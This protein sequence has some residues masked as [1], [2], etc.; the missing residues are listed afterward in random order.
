MATRYFA[1]VAGFIYLAIGMLGFVPGLRELPPPQAP[2]V[3]I[4]AAHGYLFGLFPVN[5]LHNIVHIV[6]G[7]W[8]ILAF[9]T[10]AS[11]ISFAKGLAII[12]AVFAVMGLFP[13]LNTTF[14]LVPL[15]SHDIWLHAG[16]ALIAAYFGW[17]RNRGTVRVK[18][19]D[20][21]RY[22]RSEQPR[23]SA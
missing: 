17:Y 9:K 6:L 16:T 18:V 23:R 15:H 14:G 8:G 4:E 10:L 1:I 11:S 12:Y 2:E 22:S 13:V 7:L 5:A 19:E 3:V 21:D 20:R